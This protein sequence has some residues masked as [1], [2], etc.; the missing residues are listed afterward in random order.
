MIC[1]ECPSRGQGSNGIDSDGTGTLKHHLEVGGAL[2]GKQCPH[3]EAPSIFPTLQETSLY[4]N[5]SVSKFRDW[6][7]TLLLCSQK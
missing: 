6:E 4:S 3:L 2:N 5:L 1:T 7:Y